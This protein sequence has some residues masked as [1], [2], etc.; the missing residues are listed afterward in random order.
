MVVANT[1]ALKSLDA[2][3]QAAIMAAAG[4]ATARGWEASE[5]SEKVMTARLQ[6]QGMQTREPSEALMTQ[7]RAIGTRQEQEWV[8]KAGPD[9]KAM[10]DRY[11]ALLSK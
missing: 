3:T 8:Q 9:G 7:L 10:L 4:R 11:R 5:A 6:A 1:R 2:A